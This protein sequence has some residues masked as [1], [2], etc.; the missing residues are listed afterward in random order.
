MRTSSA[1]SEATGTWLTSSFQLST[2]R[3]TGGPRCCAFVQFSSLRDAGRALADP[4]HVINGREVYIAR[5]RPRNFKLSS[6]SR[7]QPNTNMSPAMSK[8]HING[9]LYIDD[10][11]R[12][13]CDADLRNHFGRY[14]DVADIFIP[15]YGLT[16][17]PRC[18]AFVQF[19]NPIDTCRVLADPCHVINGR[20]R[21]V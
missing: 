18:C 16:G 9:R 6:V 14:G 15:T 7:A 19:S 12:G 11:A 20:Q 8:M 2:D 4:C 1:T 21:K 5:A 3:L 13:T 10:M 17:Q